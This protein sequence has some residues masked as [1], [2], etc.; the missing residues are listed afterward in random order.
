MV[1]KAIGTYELVK[2]VELVKM[3]FPRDIRI[4]GVNHVSLQRVQK[5]DGQYPSICKLLIYQ[6]VMVKTDKDSLQ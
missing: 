4:A 3:M 1:F 2:L 5:G 6:S